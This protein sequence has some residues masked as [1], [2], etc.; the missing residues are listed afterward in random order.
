MNVR[1]EPRKWMF[2]KGATSYKDKTKHGM[3]SD[4]AFTNKA[5]TATYNHDHRPQEQHVHKVGRA[6]AKGSFLQQSGVPH[7]AKRNPHEQRL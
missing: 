7:S 5:D 6:S 2:T 1:D 3:V 4:S